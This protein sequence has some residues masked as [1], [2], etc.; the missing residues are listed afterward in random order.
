M[1][2]LI[3]LILISTTAPLFAA[4]EARPAVLTNVDYRNRMALSVKVP[5]MGKFRVRA[6]FERRYRVKPKTSNAAASRF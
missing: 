5:E 4:H 1:K 3:T 6:S 2:S